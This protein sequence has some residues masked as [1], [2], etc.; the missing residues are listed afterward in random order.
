MIEGCCIQGVTGAER[1]LVL[2]PA[3]W[4]AGQVVHPG[5]HVVD[6]SCNTLRQKHKRVGFEAAVVGVLLWGGKVFLPSFLEDMVVTEVEHRVGAGHH[7]GEADILYL[8]EE[9]AAHKRETRE[10]CIESQG[11]LGEVV[12]GEVFLDRRSRER[13]VPVEGQVDPS[14][15]PCEVARGVLCSED[16]KGRKEAGSLAATGLWVGGTHAMLRAAWCAH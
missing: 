16:R 5:S 15:A 4:V 2:Q 1:G 12:D 6:S 10:S 13:S 3:R 9:G 11:S 8:C 14:E 7:L